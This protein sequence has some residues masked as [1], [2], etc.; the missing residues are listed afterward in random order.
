MGVSGERN[1]VFISK[2]VKFL[3]CGDIILLMTFVKGKQINGQL[4]HIYNC[5]KMMSVL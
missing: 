4:N 2:A 5:D 1:D 3:A